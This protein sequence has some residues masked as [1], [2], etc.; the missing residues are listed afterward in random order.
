MGAKQTTLGALVQRDRES[1]KRIIEAAFK[2][3]DVDHQ[4]VA[5][6]FRVSVRTLIRWRKLLGLLEG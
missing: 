3:C 2:D 1:A 5:R 4:A 6:R